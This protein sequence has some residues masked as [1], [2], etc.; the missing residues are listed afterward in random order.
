MSLQVIITRTVGES[1]LV[2]N[3]KKIEN[4]KPAIN[5]KMKQNTRIPDSPA[6]GINK[7]RSAESSVAITK[8][9]LDELQWRYKSQ[10]AISYGDPDSSSVKNTKYALD[11]VQRIYKLQ[12]LAFSFSQFLNS[13]RIM[14]SQHERKIYDDCQ[15]VL[16]Q[17]LKELVFDKMFPLATKNKLE[18][19][20]KELN[21]KLSG[22]SEASERILKEKLKEFYDGLIFD[23]I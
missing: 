14:M 6:S 8:R 16:N 13:N 18:L 23:I 22:P 10:L 11:R 19:A 1:T 2:G 17:I 5:H 21:E 15:T 12:L 7:Y 20:I 9:V 3:T 4:A